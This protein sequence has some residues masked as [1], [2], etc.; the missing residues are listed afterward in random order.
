[1]SRNENTTESAAQGRRAH[2]SRRSSST[3]IWD[4][5]SSSSGCKIIAMMQAA[6]SWHGYDSERWIGVVCCLTV[7]RRSICQRKMRP[8]VVIVTDVF[9]HEAFQMTFVQDNHM[10]KQIPAAVTDPTLCNTVLPRTSEARPLRLDTEALDRIN[11]FCAEVC[12]AIKDQVPGGA[13]AGECFAQLLNDPSTGRMSRY[14]AVKDAPPIMRNHEEAVKHTEGECRHREEIHRCDGLAMISKEDSPSL[15][16][17]GIPRGFPHPA[18][19]GSLR[20]IEAKHFQFA[21]NPWCTPSSVLGD[22][23]KDQF[24][25]F[26]AHAFSSCLGPMPR[27]P[28]PIQLEPRSMPMNDSLWSDKDQ[29]LFPSTPEPPQGYPEQSVR[30]SKSRLRTS[31]AQDRKLLPKRQV[32]QEEIPAR[33]KESGSGNEQKPQQG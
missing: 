29:R 1:M 26:S 16:R 10:I 27:E 9:I 6:K 19:H 13:V 28:R 2:V 14:V 18:Q 3:S 12:A 33:A 23:A 11:H 17:L 21:M 20:D 30:S 8:V 7:H 4:V 32:F 24:S 5:R 15:R 22:H 25:Q 31:F